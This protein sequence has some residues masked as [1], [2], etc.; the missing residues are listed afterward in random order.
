MKLRDMRS[1][2]VAALCASSAVLAG[3]SGA[4]APQSVAGVRA[5]Y[6]SI[7]LDAGSGDFSDVCRS[8]MDAALRDEVKRSNDDCTTSNA[9]SRLE[10]WAEKVRLS[11]VNAGTRIVLSGDQARVYDGAA[12]ESAH[13][14]HGQWQLAEVPEL[15]AAVSRSAAKS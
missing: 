4:S 1:L 3:C 13:Y 11:K 14:I 5:M 7:G 9:T 15:T 8:Y 10:R 6:R 2:L 12:P